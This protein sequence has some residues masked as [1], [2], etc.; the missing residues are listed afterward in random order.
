MV[1]L[2]PLKKAILAGLGAL[3]YAQEKVTQTIEDLAQRG[4]ITRDQ[5]SKL[6]KELASKAWKDREAF[7]EKVAAEVR[8]LLDRAPIVTRGELDALRR[9]M[10]SLRAEVEALRGGAADG[11][12]GES[13]G[14][15][16]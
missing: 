4:E 6:V 1:S 8:E 11:A 13:A 3:S 10:A 16:S 9:E 7:C 12:P 2:D 5:A 14:G 15:M